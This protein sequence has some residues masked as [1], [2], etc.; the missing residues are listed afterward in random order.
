MA[1]FEYGV[2]QGSAYSA[3]SAYNT[4]TSFIGLMAC[5]S[6]QCSYAKLCGYEYS[7]V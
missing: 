7:R 5:A 3:E 6:G 1:L 4:E 2:R